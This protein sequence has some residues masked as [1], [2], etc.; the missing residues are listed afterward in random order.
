MY[1]DQ[2]SQSVFYTYSLFGNLEIIKELS[3]QIPSGKLSSDGFGYSLDIFGP[4]LIASQLFK[5]IYV[6]GFQFLGC[7]C[8]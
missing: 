2:R 1:Y 6:V 3:G 7:M 8:L 4:C 5:Y